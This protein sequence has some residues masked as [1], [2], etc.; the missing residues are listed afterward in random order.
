MTHTDRI[1]VALAAEPWSSAADI[2]DDVGG[3]ASSVSRTLRRLYEEGRA[4]RQLARH[5]RGARRVWLYRFVGT[6]PEHL[7]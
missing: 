7:L 2:R 4:E 5:P 6:V 3:T 1:L